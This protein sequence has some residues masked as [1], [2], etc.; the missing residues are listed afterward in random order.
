MPLT[1]SLLSS[2]T[3]TSVEEKLEARLFKEIDLM[4]QAVTHVVKSLRPTNRGSKMSHELRLEIT[5]FKQRFEHAIDEYEN[6]REWVHYYEYILDVAYDIHWTMADEDAVK[7]LRYRG[8]ILQN[9]IETLQRKKLVQN[10]AARHKRIHELGKQYGLRHVGHLDPEKNPFNAICVDAYTHEQ[11][12]SREIVIN[13]IDNDQNA[14]VPQPSP[15]AVKKARDQ[16]IGRD[17]SVPPPAQDS[18]FPSEGFVTREMLHREG[19]KLYSWGTVYGFAPAADGTYSMVWAVQFSPV[20]SF[21]EVEQEAVNIFIEYMNKVRQFAHEVK[22]NRAQN[23][24]KARRFERN[25][26]EAILRLFKRRKY[27]LFRPASYVL[28]SRQ[29]GRLF[30]CGWRPG[31]K[32][33]EMAGEYTMQ[34]KHDKHDPEGYIDMHND[35]ESVAIAWMVMGE[36]ISP[37]A[38]YSNVNTLADTILPMFGSHDSDVAVHGPSLGAN[39]SVSM[40]DED[41]NNFA[42][43]MHVDSDIDALPQFYG[44]IFT[45]GQWIHVNEKQQLVEGDELREA[46]PD[47]YFVLPGYRVGFDL[48]GAAVV[49]AIWRGALD[50]HGT[51]TSTVNMESGITRWGM[52]IQ[53]NKKLPKRMRSGRGAIFG[54][55]DRLRALYEALMGSDDGSGI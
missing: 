49:T 53:T 36:R 21:N 19:F 55:F 47:G 7:T 14:T 17:Q 54:A 26:S 18:P 9:E 11:L 25:A 8:G 3:L 20:G 46:I 23:G 42:N 48:G 31:R 27:E 35:Q 12:D 45:F 52:S 15:D 38:V 50:L 39:M 34:S 4:H 41:G 32:K 51:T 10:R 13:G 43:S 28:I 30:G 40:M 22:N 1:D 29:D 6:D 44:K 37:R 2:Q 5:A 16:S 24:N 33:D